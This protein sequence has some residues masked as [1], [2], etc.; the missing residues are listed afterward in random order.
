MGDE[1]ADVKNGVGNGVGSDADDSG[2]LS[3]ED[4]EMSG[5]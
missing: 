5:K 2:L 3:D 4:A 1:A